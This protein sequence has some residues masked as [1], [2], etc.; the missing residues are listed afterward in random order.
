MACIIFRVSRFYQV[1][2]AIE[3]RMRGLARI[4]LFYGWYIVVAGLVLAAYTGSIFAYG[5]TA[6]VNPIVATFGWSMAQLSLASSL[7]S[8]ETGVFNPIWGVAVDRLSPRKLMLFGVISTT[9]GIFCLSQTRNLAMY[10][11][12][13]LIMGLGSSLVTGILPQT[14]IA[15][16]FRRDIGKANGLFYMGVAIGGVLVPVVVKIIDKLSW[17]TT[18]L[19][20]AIGFLVLGIPLSFVIRSRPEDYGLLPDGKAPDAAMGSRHVQLYDFGTTVKEALK[21]RAFWHLCVVALFQNATVSTIMLY[22]MPY[23][24]SLGMD[25]STASTVVML[26]LLVSL[27]TRIPM[28]MLSDIFR[29][30]YVIALSV[31]MMGVGLFLFWLIDG[32]S[33]LWV[34]LLFAIVYGFGVSGMMP[35]WAPVLS[36]YFG[37]KNF[38]TIFGVTSIFIALASVASPPLAG[39]IYDTYHDYKVWWLVLVAF[40]ILALIAIL[41]IPR[42]QKRTE[43]V[44]TQVVPGRVN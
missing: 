26:Y 36:E 28:G 11:G 2:R 23:L 41:T 38:G 21:M 1:L 18:L 3:E 14:V 13:F 5:W 33:P 34:I 32:T 39:W 37:T 15:R 12:G 25:R 29:K 10:Y 7:R 19:L 31:G 8:I 16:W 9:L 42:V 43:P 6:F 30:S 35:L 4:K 44:T 22:T 40:G 20:T 17:Q 27:F 24:T